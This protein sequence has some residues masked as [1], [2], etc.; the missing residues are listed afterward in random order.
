M[1]TPHSY[2]DL[3]RRRRRGGRRG[4]RTMETG[5]REFF[6][7]F[8]QETDIWDKTGIIFI[9]YFLFWHWLG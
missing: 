3:K 8:A 9:F 6:T 5:L 7:K 1:D 4:K 2:F